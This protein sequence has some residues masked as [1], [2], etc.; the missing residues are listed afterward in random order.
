[1]EEVFFLV[2]NKRK[3]DFSIIYDALFSLTL[4][5]TPSLTPSPSLFHIKKVFLDPQQHTAGE[6]KSNFSSE[7]RARKYFQHHKS[8]EIFLIELNSFK[9]SLWKDGYRCAVNCNNGT[10]PNGQRQR[11]RPA[12]L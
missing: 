11:G 4:S 3:I 5:L 1:M 7:K 12:I 2:E 6:L 9:R 8:G 10:T